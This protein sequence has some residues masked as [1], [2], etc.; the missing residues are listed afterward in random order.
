MSEKYLIYKETK[1][2]YYTEG[3]KEGEA[4]VMLHAAFA[5]HHMYCEQ[6][7]AFTH[8]YYLIMIDS[9]A[10]GKSRVGKP[11]VNMGHMPE[12][13]KQILAMEGYN[14][15]HILGTSMGSLVAQGFAHY[16]PNMIKS[17]TVVGGYSVHK[18]NRIIMKAQRKEMLKWFG[19]LIF[20]MRGF[21]N[22]ITKVSAYTS[23]GK[24][25]IA[26]GAEVYT[27][28]CLRGMQGM[29]LIMIRKDT[30]VPY[31]L[32]IVCGEHDSQLAKEAGR[33]FAESEKNGRYTEIADAGH[34]ANLDAPQIFNKLYKTFIEGL[35]E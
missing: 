13:I 23:H 22:Y 26:K 8:D 6:I 30:Q 14:V 32:L 1:I 17:M 2:F 24:E 11:N 4:I 33:A 15:A 35:V 28:S 10:H 9:I 18:D 25:V 21:R 16:Y 19:Y 12:I 27:R 34:C 20:S 5:D 31:S 29:D 7:P 3:N